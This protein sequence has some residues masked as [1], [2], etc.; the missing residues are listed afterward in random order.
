MAVIPSRLAGVPEAFAHWMSRR[1]QNAGEQRAVERHEAWRQNLAATR[2]QA[3]QA[4]AQQARAQGMITPQLLQD[5]AGKTYD[6]TY[7]I[8]EA[9]AVAA[10]IGLVG[11]K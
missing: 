6:R 4:A 8:P 2:A 7:N 1:Q 11:S 5:A 9:E 10:I 3:A